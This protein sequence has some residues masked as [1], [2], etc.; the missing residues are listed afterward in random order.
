MH[1]ARR[2]I[3]QEQYNRLFLDT[4]D[5]AIYTII[6]VFNQDIKFVELKRRI[7]ASTCLAMAIGPKIT[8]FIRQQQHLLKAEIYA[9]GFARSTLEV[10]L[11]P[12][13]VIAAVL[14]I[15]NRH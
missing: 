2:K 7:F 12:D 1:H 8:R 4:A 3:D 15:T 13:F 6:N 10:G 9:I 11:N 5:E 14:S